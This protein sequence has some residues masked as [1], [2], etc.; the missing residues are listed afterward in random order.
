VAVYAEKRLVRGIFGLGFV[1]QQAAAPVMDDRPVASIEAGEAVFRHRAGR[2]AGHW[3]NTP[4]DGH[5]QKI[6]RP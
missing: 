6:V 1:V 4:A 3:Q 2:G 5:V